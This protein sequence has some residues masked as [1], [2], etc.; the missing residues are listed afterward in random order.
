MTKIKP[1]HP[2]LSS[3]FFLCYERIGRTMTGM[4]HDPAARP[5]SREEL[6]TALACACIRCAALALAPSEIDPEKFDGL[7]ADDVKRCRDEMRQRGIRVRR[8]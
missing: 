5:L 4:R 7:L 3:F 1:P 2:T 8:L 6:C